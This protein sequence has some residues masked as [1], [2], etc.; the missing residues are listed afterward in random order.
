MARD[1]S[2]YGLTLITVLVSLCLLATGIATLFRVLPVLNNL[3]RRSRTYV[4]C[5]QLADRVFQKVEEKYAA[6]GGPE[7]PDYLEG[8]EPDLPGYTYRAWLREE[9]EGL[10]RVD[11][12]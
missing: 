5:S 2:R 7:V 11:L 3:S 9:K 1:K 10:Y 8:A 12:E 4:S 6:S